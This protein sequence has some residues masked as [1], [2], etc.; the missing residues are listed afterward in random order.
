MV[1]SACPLPL[2]FYKLLS[3]PLC[4]LL[5]AVLTDES[6]V[7]FSSQGSCFIPLTIL[8][9]CPCVF[10]N[11]TTFL[12]RCS[13]HSCTPSFCIAAKWCLLPCSQYLTSW[14]PA[15]HRLFLAA[16]AHWAD[17]FREISNSDSKISSQS[18]NFQA[19]V[20]SRKS[21]WWARHDLEER[22]LLETKQNKS[23]QDNL[24]CP[25]T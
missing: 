25:N 4:S 21:D 3:Y 12:L 11:P 17:N 10:L 5:S 18:W 20:L 16:A 23:R 6:W 19:W 24:Y 14:C 22:P 15:L 9:A 7:S 13:G 2:W 1:H 8:A